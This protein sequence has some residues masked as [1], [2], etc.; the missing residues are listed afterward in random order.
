M[1]AKLTRMMK[2]M[3]IMN[4]MRTITM[5]TS[6]MHFWT[7]RTVHSSFRLGFLKILG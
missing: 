4:M 3:S 1:V 7:V 2:M 5:M 6:S